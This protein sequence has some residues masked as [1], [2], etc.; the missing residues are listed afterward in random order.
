[1]GLKGRGQQDDISICKSVA[2]IEL[3]VA[4]EYDI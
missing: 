1:M 2:E 4:S 3:V